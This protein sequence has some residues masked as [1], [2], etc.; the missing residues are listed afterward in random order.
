[1]KT[2]RTKTKTEDRSAQLAHARAVRDQRYQDLKNL[3]PEKFVA[4]AGDN[5][6]PPRLLDKAEVLRRVPFTFPTLWKMMRENK[7]PMSRVSGGTKTVWLESEVNQWILN[8]PLSK[9][10]A[11][12]EIAEAE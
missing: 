7:F 4:E 8:R 12:D 9:L 6:D 2:P 10:K 5:G 3:P 1:M 11:P